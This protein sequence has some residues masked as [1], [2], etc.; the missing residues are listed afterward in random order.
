MSTAT[1]EVSGA[2]AAAWAA[3]LRATLVANVRPGDSV[4]PVELQ[5][6]AE[7]VV[8]VIGLVFAGVETAKTI[9]DWWHSRRPE[10]ITVTILVSDGAQVDVSV[11]SEAELE[12]VFQR[13]ASRR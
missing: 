11:V 13:A 2:D 5:R 9:R 8:A 1:V 10:G 3:E 4:S 7:L 12:I 6:S